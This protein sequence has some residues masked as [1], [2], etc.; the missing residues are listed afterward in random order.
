MV[1]VF[2]LLAAWC[3]FGA[4]GMDFVFWLPG[5][6]CKLG[7]AGMVFVFWLGAARLLVDKFARGLA[8]F[9]PLGV[10]YF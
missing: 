5:A 4:M 8:W 6:W 1:F 9:P 10:A 3:K 7:A 2:W